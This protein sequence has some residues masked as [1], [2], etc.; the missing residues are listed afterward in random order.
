MSCNVSG[1]LRSGSS[2]GAWSALFL[3]RRSV[4]PRKVQSNALSI[5]EL[6]GEWIAM[7]R[8]FG[9]LV[10]VGTINI[11]PGIQVVFVLWWAFFTES[12]SGTASAVTV[13]V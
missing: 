8:S 12:L 7:R 6:Q 1:P 10:D 5:K 3:L 13:S 4:A 9:P 11:F 2:T